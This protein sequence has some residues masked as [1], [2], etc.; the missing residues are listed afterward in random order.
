MGNDGGVSVAVHQQQFEV[1]K[2]VHEHFSVTGGEHVSGSLVGSVSNFGH[3][4]L[5]LE[6]STNLGAC[7]SVMQAHAS[8][9]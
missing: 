6:S 8:A 7:A 1:G 9:S 5:T 2:V 4:S 3:G